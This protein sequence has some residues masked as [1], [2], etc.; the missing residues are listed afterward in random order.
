MIIRH[1]QGKD[2]ELKGISYSTPE[3]AAVFAKIV[4]IVEGND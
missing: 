1:R 4:N 2:M 3:L